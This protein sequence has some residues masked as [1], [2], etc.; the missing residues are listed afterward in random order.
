MKVM[1]GQM[2]I[3][4]KKEEAKGKIQRATDQ[5]Q[6]KSKAQKDKMTSATDMLL[7]GVKQNVNTQQ[8]KLGASIADVDKRM[9]EAAA[10][11]EKEVASNKKDS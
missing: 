5:V 11:K 10:M 4:K 1:Q 8:R 6:D 7:Q 9:K 2:E 3:F